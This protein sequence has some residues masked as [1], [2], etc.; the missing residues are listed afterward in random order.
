MS[1]PREHEAA[2]YLEKH[3]IIELMDNLTSMLFFYR[4]DRPR[5]FLIDQLE[6]LSLSKAREGNTPCLFNESNLD[7]LFGVLDPSH[8]GFITHGQ[9]KEALKTLG[10]KNFN[11]FPD[12]ASDDRI[13][14][15]TFIREATEGLVRSSATFQL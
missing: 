7:A 8:Q 2:E 3:K 11:E 15:E 14:Q 10:I 1:S 13:S 4:P 5:E 6:K 9:Y 12:G